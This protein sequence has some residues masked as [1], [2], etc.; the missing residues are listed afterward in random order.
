MGV[1]IF[2]FAG[3]I[4]EQKP[5]F[6]DNLY[7]PTLTNVLLSRWTIFNGHFG[8]LVN[9]FRCEKNNGFDLTAPLAAATKEPA[10]ALT[11][12]GTSTMT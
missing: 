7:L 2:F 9:L 10:A 8:N 6:S 4:W 11:L 3:S 1:T 5:C 12:S